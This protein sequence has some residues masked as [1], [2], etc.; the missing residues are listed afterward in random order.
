[1]ARVPSMFRTPLRLTAAQVG[2]CL[3]RHVIDL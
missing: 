2:I 3:D 1:M